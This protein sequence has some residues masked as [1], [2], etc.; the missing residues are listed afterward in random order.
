MGYNFF[1]ATYAFIS[2]TSTSSAITVPANAAFLRLRRTTALGPD[3]YTG[4]II[5]GSV[6][7]NLTHPNVSDLTRRVS[8]AEATINILP[9]TIRLAVESHIAPAPLVHGWEPN[10]WDLNTGAHANSATAIR[11]TRDIPVMPGEQF[12][13]Q[14]ASGASRTFRYFWYTSAGVFISHTQTS[15]A[16]AAPANA[17]ILRVS[18]TYPD[19]NDFT[20]TVVRGN[21]R[22]DMRNRTVSA[23]TLLMQNNF[24]NLRVAKGEVI[25]QINIS[26]ES[27][28]I[29]GNKIRI[30]GQTTID[31]AVIERAMIADAAIDNAKIANLNASKIN[32]GT[33]AAA[34]IAAGSITSDKLTIA[35]GFITNAMI[36]NLSAVKITTGLLQ[37]ANS[38]SW[39]N[40]DNGR[41][42]FA[43][44]AL[45]WNG[46]A[47][48]LKSAN[49]SIHS[50][51]QLDQGRLFFYRNPPG[52]ATETVG[53]LIGQKDLMVLQA[54]APPTLDQFNP[55]GILLRAFGLAGRTYSIF[56]SSNGNHVVTGNLSFALNNGG[57]SNSLIESE[58]RDLLLSAPFNNVIARGAHVNLNTV[59][60]GFIRFQ[61]NGVDRG[62]FDTNT[63]RMATAGYDIASKEEIKDNIK[64]CPEALDIIA[65]AEIYSYTLKAEGKTAKKHYGFVIGEDRKT[66]DAVLSETGKHIDLYSMAA[67]S[68]KGV[69]ELW[70]KCKKYEARIAVLERREII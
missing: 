55:Q 53:T 27:I 2:F 64:P 37:S 39:I 17:A 38:A 70:E 46:T 61:R 24:I 60:N 54:M 43:S 30:T 51:I 25:N 65:N 41:F 62:W 4:N 22:I 56:V 16:I 58:F 67:L 42:S 12:I 59:A 40:M 19:P 52:Q 57:F 31:N 66:P 28:L 69:Q 18:T 6:R 68:W 26:P 21:T 44:G 10:R 49:T 20:G 9:T 50:E 7:L 35:N 32:A 1:T 23:S 3:R 15:N 5:P 11:G 48:V 45:S 36:N 33:L 63:G 29:A 14:E 47:L 8:T 34:R 13:G